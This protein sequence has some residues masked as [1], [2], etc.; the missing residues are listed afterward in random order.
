MKNKLISYLLICP[1]WIKF[2]NKSRNNL[3]IIRNKFRKIQ[4][5]TKFKNHFRLRRAQINRNDLFIEYY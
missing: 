2:N 1:V 5:T 3:K 4:I